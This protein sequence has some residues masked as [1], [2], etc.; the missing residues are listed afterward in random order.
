MPSYESTEDCSY[1]YGDQKYLYNITADPSELVDLSTVHPQLVSTLEAKLAGYEATMVSPA[2]RNS[3]Y[4]LAY[5]A[6]AG[7]NSN[8]IGPFDD[9]VEVALTGLVGNTAGD[10]NDDK[11]VN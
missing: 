9:P 1:E 4:D 6:W 3:N 11:A 7:L 5:S 8:F 10:M 2:Y